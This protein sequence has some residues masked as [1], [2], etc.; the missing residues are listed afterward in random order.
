MAVALS[1]VLGCSASSARAGGGPLDGK[2]WEKVGAA[3]ACIPA[4]PG[5]TLT[6]GGDE[7]HNYGHEDVIVDKVS[8]LRPKGLRLVDAIVLPTRSTFLGY[9]N[10]Y[11]PSKFFIDGVRS[12][13]NHRRPA[14]GMT[15]APQ[16]DTTSDTART[17]NLVV[18]LRV[19]GDTKVGMAAVLVDYHVG[20]TKYRWHN[21]TS[22]VV[23]TKKAA[24]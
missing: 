4:K 23:E 6:F 9:D 18:A 1:T 16:P 5:A 24:C 7:L 14:A 13:W 11:P 2:D 10:H 12:A 19:T 15:I 22:L 8:L 20:G 17:H 3:Q 21:I